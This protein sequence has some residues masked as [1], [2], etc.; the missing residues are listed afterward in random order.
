MKSKLFLIAETPAD[1]LAHACKVY[2]VG[3]NPPQTEE[4]SLAGDK[5]THIATAGGKATTTTL[6][7]G[8]DPVEDVNS[9]DGTSCKVTYAYCVWVSF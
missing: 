3:A 8:A 2:A 1:Q 7:L 9:V 4:I 6:T 5:L